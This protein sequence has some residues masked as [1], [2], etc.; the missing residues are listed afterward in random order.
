[1]IRET[2]WRWFDFP[3]EMFSWLWR[4]DAI[5][6]SVSIFLVLRIVT[7]VLALIQF[8]IAPVG[9]PSL[10]WFDPVTRVGNASGE[11]YEMSLPP[12]SPL[13]GIVAPWRVYDTAWYIKIAIQGYRHD[14]GIVFPPLY[15]IMIALVVPFL[16]G[17]YVL[18]A[19]LVSN[20]FC[21]M[22]FF[23]LYKLIQ[24]E[25]GD[26]KLATR[27]LI[28]LAA[29]PTAFYL[30]AGYT[31][32]IF[33]ALTL[34]AFLAA[35]DQRWWLAGGLAFLASLARLQGIALCLPL[36]WIAYIQCRPQR[37]TDWRTM[38]A[39]VPTAVGAALG[40]LS[41]VGYITL[42]N[43]GS[44]EAAYNDGWKLTTRWPWE[45]I[46]TYFDRLSLGIVPEHENNNAL[47]LL[48]MILL[49]VMV[50]VKM[51]PV[52]ALYAWSTLFV[53]MLR[54]HYG[55]LLEGAQFESAFRYVLLLFPCF[56]AAAMLIRRYWQLALY[57]LVTIQWQVY[58]LY[59]FTH[60]HWVA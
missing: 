54:Y 48:I 17:N 19:L 16:G 56:I 49:A 40:T 29:F 42:N 55:M 51:R 21:L 20:L 31:E 30:M 15:P 7:G 58:L 27:T 1:M 38:L 26:N 8:A 24:R 37:W 10:L 36:A 14:N 4:D 35:F 50:T 22:A 52:Y 28:L 18:A 39:R 41:Y 3:G 57:G 2:Q 34:G 46:R 53:I 33:L 45:S 13:A 25:F 6:T 11:T 60:W 5:R 23:L 47:I 9:K 43:L 44:F 32:P 12:N 59:N